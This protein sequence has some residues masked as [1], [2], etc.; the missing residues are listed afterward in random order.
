[1]CTAFASY[2]AQISPLD[3]RAR[4]SFR[5]IHTHTR[6]TGQGRQTRACTCVYATVKFDAV[7]AHCTAGLIMLRA[8]RRFTGL[9]N[10][11]DGLS[12]FR[13]EINAT[14]DARDERRQRDTSLL[15]SAGNVRVPTRLIGSARV[16][17]SES[18]QAAA[19]A[20]RVVAIDSF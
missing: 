9:S 17:P 12:N 11:S 10:V 2:T 13:Y 6:V 19:A 14:D 3:C 8:E 5:R 18:P 15:L 4:A 20:A 1:M 16:G 7:C